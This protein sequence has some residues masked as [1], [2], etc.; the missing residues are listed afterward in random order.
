[1]EPKFLAEGPTGTVQIDPGRIDLTPGIE[2]D[3][4]RDGTPS[5][6]WPVV[7]MIVI[8]RDRE[9]RVAL[10]PGHVDLLVEHAR[11][12]RLSVRAAPIT[13]PVIEPITEESA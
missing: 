5:A 7:E 13:D 8:T 3:K 1:M 6:P 11:Q 12:A 2:F 4:H 9:V 10:A